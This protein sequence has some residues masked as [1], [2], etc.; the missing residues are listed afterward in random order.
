MPRKPIN[1]YRKAMGK[2]RKCI[3]QSLFVVVFALLMC[4]VFG[5]SPHLFNGTLTG[6]QWY[7]DLFAL[8]ALPVLLVL[9]LFK[10]RFSL[11]AIDLLVG[12]LIVVWPKQLQCLVL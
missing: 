4:S 3:L 8:C 5:L 2:L 10:S 9:L 11:T 12:A 6:K 1:R 7:T